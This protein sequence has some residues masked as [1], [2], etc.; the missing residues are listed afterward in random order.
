MKIYHIYLMKKS[1]MYLEIHIFQGIGNQKNIL[2]SI[3]ES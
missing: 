1:L 3:L 2:K